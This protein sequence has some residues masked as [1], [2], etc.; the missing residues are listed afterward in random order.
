[1]AYLIFGEKQE[2]LLHHDYVSLRLRSGAPV[3]MCCWTLATNTDLY[4]ILLRDVY[5]IETGFEARTSLMNAVV[6]IFFG[7]LLCTVLAMAI[8]QWTNEWSN[9]GDE[10]AMQRD[11]RLVV[12]VGV[13]VSVVPGSIVGLL[14]IVGKLRKRQRITLLPLSYSLRLCA[15]ACLQG[16]RMFISAARREEAR[17]AARTASAAPRPSTSN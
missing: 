17:T 13:L 5:F 6:G 14:G 16:G 7:G 1:M 2:L 15:L 11:L 8:V 12:D 3:C 9:T 4:N 10:T